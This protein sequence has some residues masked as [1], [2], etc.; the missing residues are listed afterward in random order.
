MNRAAL[1]AVLVLAP[2]ILCG[3]PK[4]ATDVVARVR[5]MRDATDFTASGR[6]VRVEAG[7]QRKAYQIS[8]KAKAFADATSIFCEVTDPAPSRVRALLEIRTRGKSSIRV[9][10][11]GD[12]AP[13][14]LPFANWVDPL[15]DSNLSYEDLMESHFSWRGQKL[16]EPAR[17][18]ARDCYVLKSEPGSTDR[19]HYASVT[20]WLDREIYYPVKAEK[21]LK[22][23]G[24]VKEF[25]Y[26]GLRKTKGLWSASQIE[27]RSKGKSYST[28]LIITRGSGK[29]RLTRADFDPRLLTRKP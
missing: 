19:S 18:G 12:A 27:V 8:L 2:A 26:Y 17:Y 7:G 29:A 23:S 20:S 13:R 3:Q 11:A 22:S 25:L 21:V 9:C 4:P 14:E 28:F 16:L 5:A 1:F 6:L 24:I 15:L 10:R